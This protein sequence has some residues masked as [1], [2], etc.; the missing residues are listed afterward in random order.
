MRIK[1][2]ENLPSTLVSLLDSH[3][4]DVHTVQM[5]GLAGAQ[6]RD[7]WSAVQHET[8]LLI[9]QDLD[10]SDIR[11]FAPGTH[12]G[13]LLLRLKRVGL[14]AIEERMEEVVK[15]SD[16]STWFACLVVV[17]DSKFAFCDRMAET[18]KAYPL[19][20][21]FSARTL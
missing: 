1:L 20:C 9:T 2:D 15:L 12:S 11:K 7:V 6:D 21:T 19:P 16:F 4:H 10:F 13:I 14:V 17:T 3:G 18:T 8:R 5:E